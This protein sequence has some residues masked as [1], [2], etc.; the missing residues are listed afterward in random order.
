MAGNSCKKMEKISAIYELSKW[1]RQIH[2]EK[3]DYFVLTI[4]SSNN[5]IE[6]KNSLY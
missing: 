1:P 3:F 4:L 5:L 2:F 6:S